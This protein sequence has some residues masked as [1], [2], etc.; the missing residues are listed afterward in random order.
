MSAAAADQCLNDLQG[1]STSTPH[2]FAMWGPERPQR[3]ERLAQISFVNM[4]SASIM[5]VNLR[6]TNQ[7]VVTYMVVTG[8]K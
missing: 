6:V 8:I 7:K 3:S 1:I 5:C 2:Y 4:M